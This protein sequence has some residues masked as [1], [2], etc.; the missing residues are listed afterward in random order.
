MSDSLRPH[1]LKHTRLPALR[2]LLEL[3]QSHDIALEPAR[4]VEKK[5]FSELKCSSL[6]M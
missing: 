3:V 4:Y 1:E 5:T 6:K 2:Y